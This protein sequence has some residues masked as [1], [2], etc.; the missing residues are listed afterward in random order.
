MVYDKYKVWIQKSENAIILEKFKHSVESLIQYIFPVLAIREA[1]YSG[2]MS[3]NHFVQTIGWLKSKIFAN[4][5]EHNK[6]IETN[7]DSLW[8]EFAER[9][10][11]PPLNELLSEI[12]DFTTIGQKIMENNV[13]IQKEKLSES[14][15]DYIFKGQ[16]FSGGVAFGI[17]KVIKSIKDVYIIN[18]GDIGYFSLFSVD[19][20]E[21]IKKCSGI[22]GRYGEHGI[23]GRTGHLAI[24]C[25][26]LGIPYIVYDGNGIH[27]GQIAYLDGDEGTI[28]IIQNM[29]DIKTLLS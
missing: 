29:K 4:S 14:Q 6:E 25:R 26:A 10:K 12:N 24:T 1:Y 9:H 3:I 20:I 18:E 11:L 17:V 7:F 21:G 2:K 28:T 15:N 27:Q 5:L 16:S 13:S 23:S 19:L 8:S 22:I